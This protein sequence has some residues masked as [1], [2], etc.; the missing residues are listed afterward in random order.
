MTRFNRVKARFLS[1]WNP[2]VLT[3]RDQIVLV[4]VFTIQALLRG[5]DYLTFDTAWNEERH[6]FAE[7]F[8]LNSKDELFG[9]FFVLAALTL[10]IGAALKYHLAV[11]FGHAALTVLYFTSAASIT[12][13]VFNQLYHDTFS[14]TLRAP[15]VL[16]IGF[17]FH[18]FMSIRTGVDPLDQGKTDDEVEISDVMIEPRK[19]EAK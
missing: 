7:F 16:W 10:M 12:V 13:S 18:F 8:S 5:I 15:G 11:W 19:G 9:I 3:P 14:S 2:G 1:I 4:A 6:F 17:W